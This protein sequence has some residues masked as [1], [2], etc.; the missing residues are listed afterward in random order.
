MNL[1]RRQPGNISQPVK[2]RRSTTVAGSSAATSLFDTMSFFP[3]TPA[4]PALVEGAVGEG[5]GSAI[6]RA[7][8]SPTADY[9]PATFF[10]GNMSDATRKP[11]PWAN[12]HSMYPSIL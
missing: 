1:T 4:N 5:Q 12:A 3:S 2:G 10:S 11:A 7:S 9:A 8:G 6:I